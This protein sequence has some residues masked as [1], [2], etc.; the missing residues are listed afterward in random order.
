MFMME[1][2]HPFSKNHPLW[3]DRLSIGLWMYDIHP[4]LNV[5]QPWWIDDTMDLLNVIQSKE[6]PSM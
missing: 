1:V 6:Q 2:V 4:R 3:M 5:I